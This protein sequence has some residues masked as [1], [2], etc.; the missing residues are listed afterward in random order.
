MI[1]EARHGHRV[2]R[3]TAALSAVPDET[4]S[5]LCD[6]LFASLARSDQRR[7]GVD[8]VRGLIH[9]QGRKSI[10]N[11]A[12]L[13]GGGQ[14]AEQSLHH[15]VCS[16]TWQWD[17]MREALARYVAAAAPPQAWV[18]RPLVIP[19]AGENSVGVERCASPA[20]Y[21]Q[22]AVGVWLASEHMA[23][24]VNWRLLLPR[25]WLENPTRRQQAAIPDRAHPET[26][27]MCTVKACLG[28]ARGWGLPVRPL[29]VDAREMDTLSVLD[30]LRA[31]ELPHLVRVDGQLRLTVD[32]PALHAYNGGNS[33][34]GEVM[35]AAA[36]LRR[37]F[38]W[39][40]PDGT[41]RARNG[42][43]A[44]VRVRVP[45]TANGV[46]PARGRGRELMLL[47][48]SGSGQQWPCELWLTDAVATPP[49]DL[50]RLTRLVQRVGWDFT[51]IADRVGIRDFVGRSFT[52]WHRHITLASAAHA[53]TA[54]CRARPG[55]DASGL[56][57]PAAGEM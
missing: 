33:S 11:I 55:A 52:G 9:A 39:R 37:P 4:L 17:P 51:E 22:R 16:S 23:C 31:A 13:L 10:R 40:V 1:V 54:L 56:P 6:V 19:K 57:S 2:T 38:L 27:G 3:G 21:T 36:P 45:A 49:A 7:R 30:Q 44:A 26:M 41:R 28:M 24:P 18:V 50:V 46:G 12:S 8:Y 48:V 29:V 25:A 42:L 5:E 14:A 32:D 53:V 35:R 34:A 47:G 20:F 15:F 43:L